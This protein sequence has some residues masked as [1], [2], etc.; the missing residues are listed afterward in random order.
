[1]PQRSSNAHVTEE[2]LQHNRNDDLKI[3][4]P[5]ASVWRRRKRKKREGTL[6][7]MTHKELEIYPCFSMTA[8]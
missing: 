8:S 1:M 3:L 6:I 7:E 5:K 2:T 4:F